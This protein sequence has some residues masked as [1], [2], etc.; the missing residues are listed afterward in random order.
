MI[1]AFRRSLDTWIVRVFF[2]VMVA[3]FVLW[4]VGDVLR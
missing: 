4:G 1:S 2:L 3:A